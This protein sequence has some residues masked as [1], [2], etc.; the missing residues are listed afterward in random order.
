MVMLPERLY[1]VF[2]GESCHGDGPVRGTVPMTTFKEGL[3]MTK[4]NLSL[5]LERPEDYYAVEELTR[6]AFWR[7][8]RGFCDE[9]LLVHRMRNVPAFVRELDYVAEMDGRIVG[10]IMYTRARIEDASGEAHEVLTFGPLSV[11]PGYQNRGIGRAL[12]RH[13][14][15]EARKLGW[16]AIVIFGHPD[17]Y[18]RIGFRRA[19]EF[20]L[21][22]ADGKNF[23][24]FMALPLYEGALDGIQG[25]FFI[26]PVFE[27]LD[28]N[29]VLEFDKGFPPKER[30]VPVPVS[31]LMS[32]LDADKVKAVE[33]LG[34]AY[35]DELT[36]RSEREIM[37][38]EGIDEKAVEIIRQV[39]LEHGWRWG[40]K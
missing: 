14:F 2:N 7:S 4:S 24:A 17:Y 16:R 28:E 12:M 19:S 33:E 8:I 27:N 38:A 31:V 25:R 26:D 20:G 13:T 22:T 21:T 39:M 6:E 9:H 11:L 18:P 1:L 15:E 23:D 30:Y 35:L 5:R 3:S 36:H 37:S 34:C 10:N 40:T 29:D 32:R